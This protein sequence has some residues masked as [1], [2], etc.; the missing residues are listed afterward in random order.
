MCMISGHISMSSSRIQFPVDHIFVT[1]T[2]IKTTLL[3]MFAEIG[4]VSGFRNGEFS[5]RVN[6]NESG[7]I[8]EAYDTIH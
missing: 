1:G 3:S 2:K 8:G 4:D 7:D 5:G 6:V